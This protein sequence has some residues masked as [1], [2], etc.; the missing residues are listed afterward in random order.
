MALASLFDAE[1]SPGETESGYQKLA[2]PEVSRVAISRF[3]TGHGLALL[4]RPR[5]DRA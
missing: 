2:D 5:K 1:I 4:A 3:R